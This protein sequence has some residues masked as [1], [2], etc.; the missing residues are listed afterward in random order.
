MPRQKAA[1]NPVAQLPAPAL[2]DSC[3]EK[4]MAMTV[5]HTS[6]VKA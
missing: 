4:A 3:A 2:S 6:Q 5:P 1:L